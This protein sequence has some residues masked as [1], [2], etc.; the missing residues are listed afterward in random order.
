M[1]E[2]IRNMPVPDTE[3]FH[4][5]FEPAYCVLLDSEYCS[6]GRMI[7]VEACEAAGRTYHDG[8]SL[9]ELVPEL[10]V[11]WDEVKAFDE[12][13]GYGAFQFGRLYHSEEYARIAAAYDLATERALAAGPCLIHDRG[14]VKVVKRLGFAYVR[15]MTY[16]TDVGPKRERCK[17]SPLYAHLTKEWDIDKAISYENGLRSRWHSLCEPGDPAWGK[18]ETYAVMINSGV[19]GKDLSAALLARL[20]A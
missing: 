15:A 4:V 20:M 16:G 2:D 3:A 7:A 11:G 9:L 6:M 18:S 5:A 17:A 12:R 1:A 10:G 19:L 14:S 8:R 13:I